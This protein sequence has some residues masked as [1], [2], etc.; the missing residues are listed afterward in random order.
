MVTDAL[1]MDHIIS[2]LGKGYRFFFR[3]VKLYSRET[4]HLI[5][6]VCDVLIMMSGNFDFV[7][8]S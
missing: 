5:S 1:L 6:F 7:I 3:Y 4:I 8:V 2:K